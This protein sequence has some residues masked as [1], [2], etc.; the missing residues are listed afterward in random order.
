M[1]RSRSAAQPFAARAQQPARTPVVGFLKLM[2]SP[3]SS[4]KPRS[5]V[6]K[7]RTPEEI[8]AG[9]LFL[10]SDESRF[11]T[12]TILTSHGGMTAQ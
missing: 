12:D 3:R 6:F 2:C 4:A 1:R 5:V 9:I 7:A 11:A 10:A 8:A